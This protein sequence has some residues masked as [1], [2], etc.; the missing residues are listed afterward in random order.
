MSTKQLLKDPWAR[1]AG[2][3]ILALVAGLFL[4]QFGTTPAQAAEPYSTQSKPGNVLLAPQAQIVIQ[5]NGSTV[6]PEAPMIAKADVVEST[7]DAKLVKVEDH[8]SN[9]IV[10]SSITPNDDS[11]WAQI[12]AIG[13]KLGC[14]VTTNP[15]KHDDAGAVKGVSELSKDE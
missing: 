4:S 3:L 10:C 7:S 15:F 13:K 2:V 5:P 1:G 8:S 14:Y 9:S 6:A 11:T 12:Q